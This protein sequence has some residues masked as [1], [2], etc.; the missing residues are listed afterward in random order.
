MQAVCGKFALLRLTLTGRE[1][2]NRGLP[3]EFCPTSAKSFD[4]RL[5]R[6]RRPNGFVASIARDSSEVVCQSVRWRHRLVMDKAAV[7]LHLLLAQVGFLQ[8]LTT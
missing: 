6:L 7:F 8:L 3:R 5:H 2:S 4:S 1:K